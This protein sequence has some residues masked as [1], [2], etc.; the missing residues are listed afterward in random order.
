[1]PDPLGDSRVWLRKGRLQHAEGVTFWS[2]GPRDQPQQ[3]LIRALSAARAAGMDMDVA[4]ADAVSDVGVFLAARA[5][6]SAQLQLG[7]SL[8]THPHHLNAP[9][10]RV[11][12]RGLR[13]IRHPDAVA[14]AYRDRMQDA[15]SAQVDSPQQIQGLDV[16]ALRTL[17][18]ARVMDTL[19]LLIQHG[20]RGQRERTQHT[21]RAVDLLVHLGLLRIGTTRS[22]PKPLAWDRDL[23]GPLPDWDSGPLPEPDPGP[24]RPRITPEQVSSGSQQISRP[25]EYLG[26]IEGDEDMPTEP[27]PV[28][29]PAESELLRLARLTRELNPLIV[30]ELDPNRLQQTVPR[31]LLFRS[32][33]AGA[34]RVHPD[35]FRSAPEDLRQAA[36]QLKDVLEIARSDMEDA[37]V[38]ATWLREL[39]QFYKLPSKVSLSEK[40]EAAELF[41]QARLHA[42]DRNWDRAHKAAEKAQRIDDADHYKILSIFCAVALRRLGPRDAVL[43]LDALDLPDP[44][45]RAQAQV[46][47]GRILRAARRI[48]DAD[49][50]FRAALALD[51]NRT[52][53]RDALQDQ[54]Q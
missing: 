40:R 13:E 38:L 54:T 17:Q 11:F 43:N 27:I 34:K 33:D 18:Q 10:L 5:R 47:A 21:W 19:G 32:F 26:P 41:E 37:R 44:R 48:D 25:V 35:R 45:Q 12:A 23:S 1:M 39:R 6:R 29:R 36:D 7:S 52:D 14:N 3:S 16:I 2:I 24:W 22:A 42:A 30:M 51:P 4:R 50:R 28:L 20:G 31:R 15:V 49:D 8:T 9:L 53:A 46:T